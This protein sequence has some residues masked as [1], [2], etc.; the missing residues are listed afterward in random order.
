MN[1]N[2]EIQDFDTLVNGILWAS[3]PNVN[4]EIETDD[5]VNEV[6]L[7]IASQIMTEDSSL[8]NEV[9]YRVEDVL[10]LNEEVVND[11]E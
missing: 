10:T 9:M 4:D 6:C 11:Y 2:L 1:L 8:H 3:I 5:L 7:N